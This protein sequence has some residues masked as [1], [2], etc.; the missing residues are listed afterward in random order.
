MPHSRT[1][2]WHICTIRI[3]EQQQLHPY[4]SP[5]TL[6]SPCICTFR[7]AC[8]VTTREFVGT[9]NPKYLCALSPL[10]V[11]AHLALQAACD[12]D[13]PVWGFRQC[14]WRM[15]CRLW[16]ETQASMPCN[17]SPP[18]VWTLTGLTQLQGRDGPRLSA[19]K[20]TAGSQIIF[21]P[22]DTAAQRVRAWA[23]LPPMSPAA[24]SAQAPTAG[25]ARALVGCHAPA[26]PATMTA[27]AGGSTQA[28]LP[29]QHACSAAAAISCPGQPIQASA[30]AQQ[31]TAAAAGLE[32]AV[33]AASMQ[34]KQEVQ[35]GERMHYSSVRA[36]RHLD[37]AQSDSSQ[38]RQGQQ[39]EQRQQ[40]STALQPSVA[41]SQIRQH[42]SLPPAATATHTA[43]N[44]ESMLEAPIEGPSHAS[45]SMPAQQLS[46]GPQAPHQQQLDSLLQQQHLHST[47]VEISAIVPPAIGHANGIHF[48]SSAAQHVPSQASTVAYTGNTQ[49][50]WAHPF[51]TQIPA[52]QLAGTQHVSQASQR[53]RDA[54]M[55]GH[56]RQAGLQSRACSP[57]PENCGPQ[58]AGRSSH[59]GLDEVAGPSSSQVIGT[60]AH[61]LFLS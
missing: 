7:S 30:P 24:D 15:L 35:H 2:L 18:V 57:M 55:P 21:R 13:H 61:A 34:L 3:G 10:K 25:P 47:P 43:Q 60:P 17:S 46:I 53:L 41:S 29:A 22:S 19:L 1:S 16:P 54:A 33:P 6:E 27:V 9:L 52:S 32:A 58:A 38:D 12:S 49:N 51:L 48:H 14:I 59:A 8:H 50:L 31:G 26:S 44:E 28:S 39:P 23:G 4:V 40:S 37:Q 20:S 42:A 45:A 36:D 11:G 5:A 56:D